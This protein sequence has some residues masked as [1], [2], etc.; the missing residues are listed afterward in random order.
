MTPL[1]SDGPTHPAMTH[2]GNIDPLTG[3][4]FVAA[5][6]V[7]FSH[8]AIPGLSGTALRMTL[9]GYAGVTLFFVLS[10]FVIAY[11]YLERFEARMTVGNVGEYLAARFARVYPLYLGFIVLGWLVQG[12]PGIPWAHL[13]AIQTWSPDAELAFSLNGP[14]WSIGVEV[15]LYLAFL[16]LVPLVVR[17]GVLSSLRRL[18][19]ATALVA[20]AMVCAAAYFTW[21]GQ[22]ALPP[23]DPASGHRWLYRMPATR[24]GDF[25]LGIFGA[26]YFMRFAKADRASVRRWGYVTLLAAIMLLVFMAIPKNYRSAFSWDVAYALPSIVAII[27]LAINQQTLI[28]RV[29]SSPALIL[30]GEASYALYLV[31]VPVG[32]LRFG[33]AGGLAVEFALYVIFVAMVISLAIGLHIAI[34]KPARKWVRRWLAPG[35]KVAAMPQEADTIRPKI[36]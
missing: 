5:M 1:R 36:Q 15:F 22:N 27:G 28:S 2:R 11:N 20:L 32:P 16:P 26:V 14:A 12:H 19:M 33:G 24:L 9:S 3:F 17:S 10:G 23:Q 6:M 7:F 13:L 30:L 21:N 31:H 29:L 18:Q 25:L 8:Y 35:A 34:E 4:R